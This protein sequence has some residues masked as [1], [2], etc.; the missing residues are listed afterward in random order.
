MASIKIVRY[1]ANQRKDGRAP[2]ALRIT[3]HRKPRYI[4]LKQYVLEKEWD[5]KAQRVTRSHPNSVRLNQFLLHE[6]TKANSVILDAANENLTLSSKEMIHR[7]KGVGT[8]LSFFAL[9]AERI[10]QKYQ[11]GVFTVAKSERAILHNVKDFL[12]Y[13]HTAPNEVVL[14]EIR[15]RRKERHKAGMRDKEYFHKEVARF[16][17]DTSLYFEDINQAFLE[18][19]KTFCKS[20]LGQKKR[21]TSNN[22]IFI[23]TLFNQAIKRQLVKQEHYPFAGDGEI[24]RLERGNKIGLE[25]EEIERIETL[26]LKPGTN[27]WHTRNVWLFAFY[28]AGMRIS[29]VISLK[30]SDIENGR[31]YYVMNK[32]EKPV[33]LKIPDK[34]AAILQL[35]RDSTQHEQVV[36]FP[37][38]NGVDWHDEYA[39]FTKTKNATS[40]LNRYLKHI[41][42]LCDI[43]KNLSN[44]IARHS[45]GNLAG[46]TIS[47][48]ML[49]KLYRHS[50]LKTTI[51]YQA[52]F[53]HKDADDALDSVLNGT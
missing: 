25:R 5:A 12:D 37:F 35:Y 11:S 16:R 17:A 10:E 45:F 13:R 47:P 49:Q 36:I 50:N 15:Q 28:F 9:G 30:W 40:L 33:S 31:L 1:K 7:V 2:L 52:N 39:I 46:D 53:I 48:I 23:R 4:F 41:A 6:L 44:H 26:D 29:D 27:M 43:K 32:N 20:H 3:E 19:Y 24:I 38:L 18:R 42:R 22:L 8:R 51:N 14:S 34:A 21:T